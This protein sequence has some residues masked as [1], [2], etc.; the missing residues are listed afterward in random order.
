MDEARRRCVTCSA[1]L[2]SRRRSKNR[3]LAALFG[4]LI[5]RGLP[6]DTQAVLRRQRT[7]LMTTR[8]R[9]TQPDTDRGRHRVRP[10][11]WP[12]IRHSSRALW[13]CWRWLCQYRRCAHLYDQGRLS[14][15]P[16]S[17]CRIYDGHPYAAAGPP[18]A[19]AQDDRAP[20][21]A[22]SSLARRW[23]AAMPKKRNPAL[24]AS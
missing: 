20:W 12:T 4:A 13:G 7:C 9:T 15:P 19:P 16:S 8:S 10:S 23:P 1:L 6:T 2:G 21:A 14:R 24:Q 17:V 11:C 22:R 18:A 3:R 5:G